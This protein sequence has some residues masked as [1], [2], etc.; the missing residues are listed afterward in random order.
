[1][2]RQTRDVTDEPGSWLVVVSG[3]TGSGESTLADGLVGELNATVV[4]F[5]WMMSGLRALPGVFYVMEKPME[6]QRR[7]G[8]NLLSRVAEQQLRL[9][10]SCILDLVAREE[11]RLEWEAPTRRYN[12]PFGATSSASSNLAIAAEWLGRTGA[13]RPSSVWYDSPSGDEQGP[14]PTG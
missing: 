12:A 14:C 1:M 10:S 2:L 4:S 11:P 8:W 13:E 6:M 9:G 5:D 7:N 3:W